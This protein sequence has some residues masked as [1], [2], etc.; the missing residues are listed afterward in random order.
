MVKKTIFILILLI[1]C[2]AFYFV[3]FSKPTFNSKGME[4]IYN[5]LSE[6]NNGDY[7]IYHSEAVT[8]I[9][10]V[11]AYKKSYNW[12]EFLEIK[13][14]I[15]D[16]VNQNR[17]LFAGIDRIYLESTREHDRGANHPYVRVYTSRDVGN[18]NRMEINSNIFN[19]QL[20]DTVFD[21][22][23]Y[24][25]IENEFTHNLTIELFE[26]FPH[27]KRLTIDERHIDNYEKLKE[28]L[29]KDCE[30]ELK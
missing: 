14:D 3:F 17:S 2:G 29:P 30:I 11:I 20:A 6:C 7:V 27:L 1:F 23:E 10:F 28:A 18:L 24:L 19:L 4:K 25:T 22:V 9:T 21:D 16:I 5:M 8:S 15:E 13:G 12:E 26:R